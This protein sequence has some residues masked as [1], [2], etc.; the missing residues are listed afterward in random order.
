MYESPKVEV[1]KSKNEVK[2]DAII[3]D[4]VADVEADKKATILI[5]SKAWGLSRNLFIC[6]HNV[7]LIFKLIRF[8]YYHYKKLVVD[9]FIFP[10]HRLIYH[11]NTVARGLICIT[12]AIQITKMWLP[13]QLRI[14]RTC[15]N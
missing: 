2:N 9:H 12:S 13:M 14:N 4:N 10:D 6:M 1:Q 7:K 8:L 5:E 15:K 3:C 11:F